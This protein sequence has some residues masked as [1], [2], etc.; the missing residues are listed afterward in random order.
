[1]PTAYF[2]EL[3]DSLVEV[4][5][6]QRLFRRAVTCLQANHRFGVDVVL[7]NPTRMAQKHEIVSRDTVRRTVSA[8]THRAADR[9]RLDS[10]E[11]RVFAPPRNTNMFYV[12]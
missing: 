6:H 1:M 3:L 7:V 10:T 12:I 2:V 9:V 11:L 8:W 5:Q 4:A